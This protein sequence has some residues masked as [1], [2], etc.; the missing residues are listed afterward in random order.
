MPN[1]IVATSTIYNYTSENLYFHF[2]LYFSVA[3]GSDIEKAKDIILNAAMENPNVMKGGAVPMPGVRMTA[4]ESSSVTIRLSI[5][6][7]DYNDNFYTDGV[8]RERVYNEFLEN[9]IEIPYSQ[10]DVYLKTELADGDGVKV[11]PP[12][13]KHKDKSNKE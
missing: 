11:T 10:L 2:Y 4:L 9:G 12:V 7:Y 1:D 8:I 5:Y 3:Y 13:R 6:V